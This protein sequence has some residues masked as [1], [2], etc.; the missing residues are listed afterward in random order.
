MIKETINVKGQII[1]LHKPLVMGIMNVTPDSFYAGS[2]AQ[3]EDSI[4]ARILE[5]VSEGGDIIDLGAYSARPGGADEISEAEEKARLE[6]A[7]RILSN[8]YPQL[9]YSVDTWRSNIARWAVEEYG[10]GIIN[11]ISGGSLDKGMFKTVTEL[12]VPYIL[13]HMRGTPQT[14]QTQ[15]DYT[16]VGLEVLD[17]FIQKSEEL[18]AL[19]LHDLILDPGF[20]F[21]K[22][23]E[24][25]YTLMNYIPRFIEATGLPLLVGISRKSMIYKLL[26]IDSNESLNGT[27]VLN[28]HALL[29]GAKILRVHDVRAAVEAVK[30]TEEL[31]KN[32][33]PSENPIFHIEATRN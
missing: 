24:Q 16:D 30:L 29:S 19:G 4:R 26:G 1:S 20:G 10:A 3:T 32:S 15:T 25:N 5:I 8:E 18:R 31:K 17:F 12:Q 22:T 13:M 14:M 6:K 7:L 2:R 9:I 23:L 11:D 27:S 33:L 21:A 28:T